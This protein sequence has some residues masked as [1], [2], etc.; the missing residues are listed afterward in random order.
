[1]LSAAQVKY[2]RSLR[3]KKFREIH[4]R[5]PAEG[6]RLVLDLI[7]SSFKVQEIFA[8]KEW[9][10]SNQAEI[11]KAGV[12]CTIVTEK[13][14]ERITALS[15]PGPVLALVHIPERSIRPEDISGEFTLM[16]DGISDPGNFG[17]IIRIADWFGI[18]RLVCSEDTVDLFNPK[19]VQASMGSI[20]R[21]AVHYEDLPGFL[22][23]VRGKTEVFGTYLSGENIYATDLP[24]AGIVVIGNESAGISP[25]V[26]QC[27]ERRLHIP[28]FTEANAMS[29]P[30]SLNAAA[31]T[32]IVCSEF[33]RR[34]VR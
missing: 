8:E 5:F 21:V 6:S 9:I 17:T 34:A 20:A 31:A 16:L 3:Q 25:A 22:T 15:S 29:S 33:R 7:R 28:S 10:G 32:A 23:K 12:I 11:H 27:I 2:I 18:T 4:R 26:S 1:M 30:E 14:M 19:V 24:R 13:E